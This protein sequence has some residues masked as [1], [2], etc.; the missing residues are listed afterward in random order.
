MS[1][2]VQNENKLLIDF[3]QLFSGVEQ[4]FLVYRKGCWF[5]ITTQ[6]DW[7]TKLAQFCHSITS[8]AKTNREFFAYVFR[9]SR[10]LHV[11]TSSFDWSTGFFCVFCDWLG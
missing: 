6:R 5:N 8:K 10:Q 9:A 2:V 1:N 11:F 4:F 3:N 7:L